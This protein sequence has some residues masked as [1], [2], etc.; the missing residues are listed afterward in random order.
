MSISNGVFDDVN[1]AFFSIRMTP[2]SPLTEGQF[3]QECDEYDDS[4][5]LGSCL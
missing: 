3:N 1:V 2:T 4:H 5:D